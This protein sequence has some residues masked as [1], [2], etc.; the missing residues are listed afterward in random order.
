MVSICGNLP[1]AILE[2]LQPWFLVERTFVSQPHLP[3]DQARSAL[4]SVSL[5][6]TLYPKFSEPHVKR[7]THLILWL[8]WNKR[9]DASEP[10]GEPQQLL[11]CEASKSLWGFVLGWMASTDASHT[12]VFQHLK[13]GKWA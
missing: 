5:L 9:Q 12:T 10:A 6:G 2:C 4:F 7:V 3:S 11:F 13:L 8:T 1:A